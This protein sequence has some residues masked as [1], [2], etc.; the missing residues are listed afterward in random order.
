MT[1][2]KL[3][4]APAT[5]M[6]PA[7]NR[8]LKALEKRIAAGLQTFR[9]VGA[10]LLEIRDQRLYRDTHS[11]FEAYTSERW[12]LNRARAYQLIDSA[13]VVKVLGDPEDL[14]NESQAREMATLSSD[15]AQKV[16]T[17]VER[18]ADETQRPITAS[19]IRQ[20][21]GE[22]IEPNGGNVPAET[23]TDRLVQ[24]ITRLG[25]SFQRWK[26]S[27]PNVGQRSRVNKAMKQL[28]ALVT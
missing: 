5:A 7:E 23:P 25:N 18:V 19:L 24:D 17:Q 28:I 14:V 27:K 1:E 11:S 4:Q 10:A 6:T 12:A 15:D 26:E 21:K 22:V 3:M 20:V 8:H 13:R 2:E 9:E 16:W